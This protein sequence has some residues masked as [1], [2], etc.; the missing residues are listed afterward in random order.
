MNNINND[1]QQN[2]VNGQQVLLKKFKFA[3]IKEQNYERKNRLYLAGW[4]GL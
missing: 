2:T 3:V 4:N 1:G